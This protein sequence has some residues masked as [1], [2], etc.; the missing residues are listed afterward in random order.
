[1]KHTAHLAM[2]FLA[3]TLQPACYDEPPPPGYSGPLVE[4]DAQ[5]ILGALSGREFE[6]RDGVFGGGKWRVGGFSVT[7]YEGAPLGVGPHVDLAQ[8]ERRVF[9]PMEVE[10]DAADLYRRVVGSEHPRLRSTVTSASYRRALAH[11]QK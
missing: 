5:Q 8:A 2:L 6:D 11:A 4:A 1:M 3:L 9:L 10:A 7:P